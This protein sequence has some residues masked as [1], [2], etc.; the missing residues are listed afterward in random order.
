[1]HGIIFAG[2][3]MCGRDWGM[4]KKGSDSSKGEASGLLAKMAWLLN[5]KTCLHRSRIVKKQGKSTFDILMML[6]ECILSGRSIGSCEFEGTGKD[7]FYRLMNNS[8]VNWRS[9]QGFCARK[10]IPLV[11]AY[12]KKPISWTK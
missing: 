9:F 12:G 5:L 8:E 4:A 6:F 10:M 2:T 7:A 3:S 1:M 11:L